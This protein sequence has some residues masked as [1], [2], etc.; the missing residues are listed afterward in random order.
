MLKIVSWQSVSESICDLLKLR[1]NNY[2]L[3]EDKMLTLPKVNTT[4][5]G[6]RMSRYEGAGLWDKLPN[7]YRNIS[8]HKQFKKEVSK[9][10]LAGQY[11]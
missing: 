6:L 4:T 1:E 8:N 11:D 2:N 9:I 5:Y 3:R 7:E 10:Y